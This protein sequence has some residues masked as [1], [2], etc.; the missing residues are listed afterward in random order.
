MQETLLEAAFPPNFVWGVATSAFQI[1][2]GA[3]DDGRGESIWDTFCDVPGAIA[4]GSN[5][6]IACDH[7]NRLDEDLDLMQSLG[8]PAYRFSVAW[9]RVQ[10]KGRG[11]WNVEGLAFYDRLVAGLQ[12]RGIAAHLTLYHWDLPQALQDEGGWAKRDTAH[13]FAAYARTIAARYGDMLASITT[14]NEP[15]VVAIL[16]YEAGIFAPGIKCRKTAMQAAHHLL[17]G[18]GLAIRA[19]RELKLAAPLGIVL[20]QSPIYPATDTAADVDKARVEDGKLVRWYMD[21]LLLG[22]YPADIV[23]YLGADA[24]AVEE[25]DM[26]LIASPIDFIGINY[27]TRNFASHANPWQPAPGPLGVTDMGWEVYPAGLTELLVRLQRDYRLPPLYI[28]ENGAAYQDTVVDGRIDDAARTTYLRTHIAAVH[29]AIAAG[30]DV[31]GYFA[32]SLFD[33]FEWA[34]G[35]SKRFGIVY[36]DYASGKRIP[37]ASALWYRDFIQ[38]QQRAGVA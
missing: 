15:W 30:V 17:L 5:G 1:E 36:V 18:H 22:R 4:D 10:P 26:A 35:Y 29:D 6:R 31:R 25:G 8:V 3:A 38:Q 9:P 33:N 13:H 23:D 7:Y 32:W 11:A 34:M 27:Y 21:P 28:T 19:M 37:K 24:P 2:G 12:Q 14:H 20:N 16:G